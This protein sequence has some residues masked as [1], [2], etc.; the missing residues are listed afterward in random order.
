MRSGSPIDHRVLS[1]QTR[2]A[3]MSA[4]LPRGAPLS[5]HF[6][7]SAISSSE[8]DGSFLKC[9]MPMSFSTYHGGITPA[10]GP[11]PVRALMLRAHGRT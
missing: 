7:M 5:A 9:W 11:T 4:G 1:F 6:A 8:S 10:R 2:A 3:G